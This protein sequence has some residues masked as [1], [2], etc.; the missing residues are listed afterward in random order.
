MKQSLLNPKIVNPILYVL[1][2]LCVMAIAYF[3]MQITFKF[4]EL[5][6]PAVLPSYDNLIVDTAAEDTDFSE[7]KLQ[8]I[9]SANLFGVK[10]KVIVKPVIKAKP[11]PK[12]K[13]EKLPQTRLNFTLMGVFF[14]KKENMSSAIISKGGGKEKKFFVE[15]KVFGKAV[16][17]EVH[18][19]KVILS[20]NGN[21]E[22]LRFKKEKINSI[23]SV[24]NEVNSTPNQYTQTKSNASNTRSP[25]TVAQMNIN[26]NPLGAMQD[27]QMKFANNPQEAMN[28][29]GLQIADDGGYLV[30]NASPRHIIAS[31]GLQPNDKIVSINHQVLGDLSKDKLLFSSLKPGDKARVEIKRNG[32]VFAVK[33]IIPSM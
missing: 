9:Q 4:M 30:T 19:D 3:A 11:K 18:S 28:N 21:F 26:T 23:E 1:T 32:R 15:D 24:Q 10:P 7:V 29:L 20:R 22:E 16:L 14:S 5:S 12:P 31:L 33:S 17:E 8:N 6:E 27:L 2:L 13:P 25:N